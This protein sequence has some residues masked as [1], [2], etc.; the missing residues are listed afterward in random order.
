MRT[1]LDSLFQGLLSTQQQSFFFLENEA[2][3]EGEKQQQQLAELSSKL[4]T[5]A[6]CKLVIGG[7]FALMPGHGNL[8]NGMKTEID[9]CRV[10]G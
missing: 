10:C 6:S 8:H 3:R 1:H 5:L 9:A 4:E 2:E 7:D